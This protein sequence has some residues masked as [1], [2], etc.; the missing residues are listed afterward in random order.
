MQLFEQFTAITGCASVTQQA[1]RESN[2]EKARRFGSALAGPD[3]RSQFVSAAN[4]KSV[5]PK[6]VQASERGNR[7]SE[8]LAQV[9]AVQSIEPLE[10]DAGQLMYFWATHTEPQIGVPYPHADIDTAFQVSCTMLH[11]AEQC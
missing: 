11:Y 9:A 5:K 4:S 6:P 8:F 1:E 10:I 2:R 3:S 7:E